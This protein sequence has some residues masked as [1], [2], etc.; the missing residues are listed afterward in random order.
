VNERLL[1]PYVWCRVRLSGLIKDESGEG[2]IS[3]AL[4]VLIMAFLAALMWVAFRELWG[5]TET[6]I[7]TQVGSIGGE[8]TG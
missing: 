6:K 1:R 2:V 7:D 3:V 4:A 8:P 5:D